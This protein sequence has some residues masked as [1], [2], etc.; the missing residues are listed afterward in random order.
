MDYDE[1]YSEKLDID[2]PDEA[3]ELV[4]RIFMKNGELKYRDSLSAFMKEILDEGDPGSELSWRDGVEYIY[5]IV[6]E[7]EFDNE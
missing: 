3:I 7:V 4:T 2:I 5:K 6:R 1:R